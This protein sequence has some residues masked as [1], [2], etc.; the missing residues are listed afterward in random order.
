M[1]FSNDFSALFAITPLPTMPLKNNYLCI[2]FIFFFLRCGLVQ[3][4]QNLSL[5]NNVHNLF[6]DCKHLGGYKRP[7]GY[8]QN[9]RQDMIEMWVSYEH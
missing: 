3:K 2:S 8:E 4:C 5:N 9:Y 6:I 7:D 1:T